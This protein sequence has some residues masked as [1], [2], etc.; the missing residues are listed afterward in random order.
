MK[1]KQ[2]FLNRELSWLEFNQRVLDE[3][4]N[5]ELPLL[6]RLKFLAITS[7]NLDEFFMVRVGGIE[8]LISD[9]NNQPDPAGLTPVQQRDVLSDRCRDFFDQQTVCY[10]QTIEPLLREAGIVRRL[11]ID[12]SP[13]QRSFLESYFETDVF[14]VLSPLAVTTPLPMLRN[15]GMHVG[16]RL[17]GDPT[18]DK[19]AAGS[20]FAFIPVE[21]GPSRIIMLPSESGYEYV[22]VEDVVAHFI[23]SF[24]VG[25]TIR[26]TCTF[27]LTRNADLEVVDDRS[28]SLLVQ[29]EEI[30]TARKTSPCVRLE[31][32]SGISKT[33]LR[34]FMKGLG[35][36]EE[37]IYLTRG[38]INYKA[39]FQIA[40]LSGFD[41][42]KNESWPP[43][44]SPDIPDDEPLHEII[45]RGDVLLHHPYETFD[46]VVRMV[47]EAADDSEVLAIKQV[48]YR[49]SGR[50]PIV[51]SLSRAAENGKNVTVLVELKARF[52]EQ[53]NIGWAKTLEKAGV[54][55]IYGV[56]GLKTHAKIC[57]IVR[58]ESSG[59]VRFV[60][61]GTGNYNESTARLY[62]DVSY[63]TCKPDF[64]ADASAFFNAITGYSQ[65]TSY[66]KISAAP[67]DLR[68]FLLEQIDMEIEVQRQ[69]G[70]SGIVAKL[71]SLNDETMIKALYKAS[72]AGVK[73]NLNIRGI[74]TL[75]PGIKGLSDNIQ[76]VSVVDRY[77][78]H[79]R[80][81]LF[82]RGGEEKGFISSADWMSRNLERRVELLI[83]IEPQELKSR[84][85]K[86]LKVYFKDNTNAWI[87]KSDGSY[88]RREPKKSEAAFSSQR[89]LYDQ[90]F[91]RKQDAVQ[92]QRL[93]FEV[94][95]RPSS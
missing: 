43:V 78:E 86:I 7:S 24:F 53:A 49:V 46:P 70:Q 75:R 41:A 79:S 47:D 40:G 30:I 18:P 51:K 25:E 36:R 44:A 83:P 64:G 27:R 65:P 17:A 21:P 33:L 8:K 22:F 2:L 90:A 67:I 84:L 58:R 54:Q 26:E 81:I 89:H 92:S 68:D 55:V 76:V 32:S 93:T 45:Q 11:P 80:V 62:G 12:C 14:P 77:L 16:V 34:F 56:R 72:Q 52:D 50:S 61:Y 57:L 48:L 71:N 91:Q 82:R 73:V 1:A 37:Q 85:V 29:M 60:H 35:V 69:G 74:C 13:R 63:L 5:P 39:F 95:Q 38:P 23:A 10:L 15:L 19:K 88:K 6:E 31:L 3:A 87:L 59:I 28:A 9:G 20:K 94:H 66:R 4:K 42:L